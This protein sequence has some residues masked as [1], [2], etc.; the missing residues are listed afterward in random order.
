MAGILAGV[1]DNEKN[2][3]DVLISRYTW[4]YESGKYKYNQA[5][6]KTIFEPQPEQLELDPSLVRIINDLKNNE[7]LL[8]SIY[9][10]FKESTK[11][12]KTIGGH[13]HL[14]GVCGV[15]LRRCS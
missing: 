4:N 15:R 12:K 9:N 5:L 7:T 10:G 13:Q 3:G 11:N 6:K 14:S 2:Y 1:K 8:K